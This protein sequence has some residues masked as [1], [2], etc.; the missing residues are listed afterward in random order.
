MLSNIPARTIRIWNKKPIPFILA[1]VVCNIIGYLCVA[2]FEI[3]PPV[4]YS[5]AWTTPGFLIPFLGSGANNFLSLLIGILCLGVST[6]IYMPFVM[7]SA[8][9]AQKDDDLEV[10]EVV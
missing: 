8:K 9:A 7:V 1:P 3:I 4:A 10:E 6:L 5:V 2:V